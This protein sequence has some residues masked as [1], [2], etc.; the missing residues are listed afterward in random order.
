MSY[1]KMKC[2]PLGDMSYDDNL[3]SICTKLY[4]F[5]LLCASHYS[6]HHYYEHKN[7]QKCTIAK[8]K[9]KA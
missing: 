5:S 7:V 6:Y 8:S 4:V 9:I 1:K 3:H 2:R